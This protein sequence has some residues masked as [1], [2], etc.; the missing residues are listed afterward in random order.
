V[1]ACIFDLDGVIVDTAKYHFLAWRRLAEELGITLTEEDNERLKGVGR[2]ESLE[3]ILSLGGRTLPKDELVRLA[4]RKNAWF[5][6]YI[7]SMRSE[8]IFPGA[9]E[10]FQELKKYGSKIGLASS[11]KNAQTVLTKL[12]ITETF[13]TIVDGTM[14]KESK[15]DPEIFLTAAANLSLSPEHCIVVEDAEAGVEAAK[16]AGMKCVGIGKQEQLNK[17]DAV[18][19]HIGQLSYEFFKNL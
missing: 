2:I 13:D 1:K 17:A 10:L 16:R 11:S 6:N 18:V 14:I 4:D 19:E 12:G 9:K 7:E 5:V 3:I 15:P 8:E